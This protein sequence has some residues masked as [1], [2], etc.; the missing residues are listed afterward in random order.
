LSARDVAELV[1]QRIHGDR[2]LP[3]LKL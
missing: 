3:C 2:R 1:G